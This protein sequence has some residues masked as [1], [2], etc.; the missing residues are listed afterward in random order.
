MNRTNNPWTRFAGRPLVAP[1]LLSA[2]FMHLADQ[3]DAVVGA[4]AEILHVD[5]MDGH[6]VPN[7]AISPGVVK[8]IRRGCDHF[9]DAHLMVTDPLFFAEPFITAGVDSLTFHVES[10][11]DPRE[12]I[13]A[14]REAGIGVGITVKPGTGA[15]TVK[16]YAGDVDLVLVMTVEPGFGGQ[17]FMADQ[18]DKI[19][20]VRDIVGPD[21]RVEVDGGIDPET[22]VP[23]AE[24][25]ADTFV[26]G[27]SVFGADDIPAAVK[28]LARSATP[29][30]MR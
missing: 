15:E 25:G 26:A 28:A 12:M 4:G 18:V 30:R 7:L 11:S 27:A 10:D 3:V 1:S 5:V 24:A 20:A 23:C 16:P 8:S 6:F 21:V 14:L 9:L 22:A 13:A 17:S 19:R 29:V 2:D